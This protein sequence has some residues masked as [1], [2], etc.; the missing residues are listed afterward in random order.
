[1]ALIAE[2]TLLEGSLH[3]PRKERAAARMALTD[4]LRKPPREWLS[5]P[6]VPL[7]RNGDPS[8]HFAEIR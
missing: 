8:R 4:L 3:P 5:K 2:A 1:L 6:L 7:P